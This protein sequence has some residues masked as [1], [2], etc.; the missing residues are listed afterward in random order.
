MVKPAVPESIGPTAG[1]DV[2]VITPSFNMLNYL[3]R[4]C[5]SVSDQE[6]VTHEHIVM[7]GG[8]TDGTPDW[9]ES[10]PFL[11]SRSRRDNGMY[12]AVNQGFRLATGEIVSHLNC[13]EQLLP[14]TLE[15]VKNYFREHPAVDV[16]F[17][18]V[19][20][21]RP[22]GALIAYRKCYCP[23]E[24][25]LFSAPLPVFT[26]AMF[27]RRR[28]LA[29]GCLYDASYKDIGDVELILRLMRAGFR[30]QHVPRYL[31]TFTV[32]GQ[33]R[34]AHVATIPAEV[35]RLRQLAPWY[36]RHFTAV[37]R[38]SGYFMKLLTGAYFQGSPIV[39]EIYPDAAASARAEFFARDPSFRWR[40]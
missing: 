40:W 24:P 36:V 4:C 25:I 38:C 29:N 16:L 26:A 23:A 13:D 8:S 15:F 28:V 35:K 33:N 21:V 12:D 1:L 10:Q 34:S 27:L 31:A 20:A 7:D 5:A 39:Y 18:D 30:M 22:D 11:I 37:W 9:L 2:S 3:Q 19:L 17:G 14:S 32:T 6:N